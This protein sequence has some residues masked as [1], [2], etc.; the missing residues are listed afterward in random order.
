MK[1]FFGRELSLGGEVTK[2]GDGGLGEEEEEKPDS[3]MT[4]TL[5]ER[6]ERGGC[7]DERG[8]L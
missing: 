6:E 8:L 7:R 3:A 4:R 5:E 2:V 1:T